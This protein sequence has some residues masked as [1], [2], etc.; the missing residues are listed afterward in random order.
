MSNDHRPG[1]GVQ[2]PDLDI[3]AAAPQLDQDG[4]LFIG[5]SNDLVLFLQDFHFCRKGIGQPHG[6]DLSDHHGAGTA[7][8]KSPSAARHVGGVGQ[9]RHDRRFFHHQRDQVFLAVDN[10]I[11]GNPHRQFECPDNVFY[12]AIGGGYVQVGPFFQQGHFFRG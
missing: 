11:G 8:K 7:G 1:F 3:L 12:H 2:D 10:H 6:L 4:I 9:T 5:E